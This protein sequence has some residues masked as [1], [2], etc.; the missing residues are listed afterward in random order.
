MD[1]RLS[2]CC[3]H[4]Y[5]NN[6]RIGGRRGL[7]GIVNVQKSKACKRS[8]GKLFFG[9]CSKQFFMLNRCRREERAKKLAHLRMK[10]MSIVTN[11]SNSE[12]TISRTL[13][14]EGI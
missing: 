13:S 10:H 5:K 8:I 7:F 3:E 6:V 4:R 9:Q 1:N 12:L 14:S 2:V 11:V